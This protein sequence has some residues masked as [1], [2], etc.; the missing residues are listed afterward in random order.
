MLGASRK[1][2]DPLGFEGNPLTSDGPRYD[3]NRQYLIDYPELAIAG[4]T[5]SWL[6]ETCKAMDELQSSDFQ[7][8]IHTPSLLITAS[9]DTIV[10]SNLIEQFAAE[11][12]AAYAVGIA[13]SRHEIMME[14]DILRQ[15]F[16][17]AFDSFIPG[18]NTH[19][20]ADV[21]R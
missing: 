15:Q 8:T 20:R 13:G 2:I 17:A 10:N 3:R 19:I 5:A 11:T 14:R 4:P 1:P 6:H 18:S 21:V 16:W 12:R 7:A 9:Q